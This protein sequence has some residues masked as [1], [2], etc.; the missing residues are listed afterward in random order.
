VQ[1]PHIDTAIPKRRYQV[2]PYQAVVLDEIES[3]DPVRYRFI[4]ALVRG[5]ESQPSLFVTAVK[6]PRSQAHGGS[7]RLQL[8]SEPATQ[9]LGSSD[10]FANV[11]GFAD[12]ALAAAIEALGLV[13]VAPVRVA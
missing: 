1:A 2:G 7:H 12:A 13:G 5:G 6:N 10:S 9:E 4:L 3:P 8:I 11:D